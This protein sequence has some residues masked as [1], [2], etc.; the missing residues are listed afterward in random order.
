MDTYAV[1]LIAVY[2]ASMIIS[3]YIAYFS[4]KA[5]RRTKMSSMRSLTTGFGIISIGFIMGGGLDWLTTLDLKVVVTT[6]SV[7]MATGLAFLLYSLFIEDI[8]PDDS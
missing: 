4:F 1:L 8:N 6:Q 5:Y 7:L 2:T 3:G